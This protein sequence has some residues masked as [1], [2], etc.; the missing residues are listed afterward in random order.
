MCFY[1]STNGSIVT[2]VSAFVPGFCAAF[3]QAAS[4]S[5]PMYRH[6]SVHSSLGAAL[7]E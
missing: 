7:L 5:G 1:L 3:W 4:V 6:A 2:P